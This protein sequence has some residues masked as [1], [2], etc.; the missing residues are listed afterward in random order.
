VDRPWSPPA[1]YF[2]KR[3]AEDWLRDKLHELR[4]AGGYAPDPS[5]ADGRP[6]RL[7]SPPAPQP[8]QTGATFADAAAEYLR[9]S[10]QDRGC[11]PATLRNYRNAIKTHLLPVFGDMALEEIT[12]REIERWR[13]GMSSAR[14]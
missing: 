10:E 7:S 9:C 13:S 11:K 4:F 2:T 6:G 3:L 8:V 1:G 14:Q 5:A 12:V